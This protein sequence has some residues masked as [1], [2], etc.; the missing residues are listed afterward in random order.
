VWSGYDL[1]LHLD[2]TIEDA[3]TK[4]TA[5][6][7]LT[8]GIVAAKFGSGRTFDGDD[9][10]IVVGS[11]TAID[12]VF[13]GGGT[14][15]AWFL[16]DSYGEMGFGRLFDKGHVTGWSFAVN[17]MTATGSFSFVH[18][19]NASSFGEWIGPSSAVGLGA[20][21]HAAVVFNSNANTVDPIVYIDG[22]AIA[23]SELVSPVGASDSDASFDLYIG[24]RAAADR[25]FDGALD[26]LRLSPQPRSS[27]WVVTQF[28][29]QSSPSSFYTV[30]APM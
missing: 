24:N 14:A 12:N 4:S 9:D 28:R 2:N 17:N 25:A 5:F 13:T 23:T 19:S 26:E 6:N 11:A 18:G 20:W 21:H 7:D 29:N 15:E 30:L 1:V 22:V 8:S 10:A 3:T 27:G 16:A